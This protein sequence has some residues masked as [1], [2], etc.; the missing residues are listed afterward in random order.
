MPAA[1]QTQRAGSSIISPEFDHF[2][3]R[4]D[5]EQKLGTPIFLENDANAAALGEKWIGA[6][7]DVQDLVLLTLGT[8]VG[9]GIIS[10]GRVIHGHVGMAGELGHVTVDRDGERVFLPLW[11]TTPFLTTWWLRGEPRGFSLGRRAS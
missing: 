7:R 3:I 4:D 1:T 2:P 6:G 9:G 11:H 10:S 8:G 5:I